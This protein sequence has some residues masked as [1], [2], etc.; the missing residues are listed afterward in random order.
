MPNRRD[1]LKTVAGAAAGLAVGADTFAQGAA[2]ARRRAM[3]AGRRVT[4]VDVHAHTFVPEVWDLVKDTPL[5]ASARN[6]LTG[7][8]ALG[9]G[10]AARLQYMDKE[11]ID[12]QAINV[13]A[14]GYSADRALARDLV[15]LQNEKI[16]AA[17]A[18]YPDRFVGMAT[19]ALQHPDLAADQLD[20]A[21]NK[22]GLRGGA[23]GGSVEGQELSDRKFDP[24]WAKAEQLG[25]L[26]FM[27]PQQA[28]GTT[29]NPRLNGKGALGNRIGNPLETTVFLSHLIF[30]GVFDRFPGLRICGA[31]AGGYLASYSGRSDAGCDRAAGD[32][33]RAL[34]K[35]PSEYFKKEIVIDTMIFHEEGLRHLV[36]EVGVGQM[37][38]G[39]DYPFDWPVGIDFIL[40]APFLSNADKEAMLGGNAMKMLRITS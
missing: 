38:Y 2:G 14:W 17:V 33:C 5:A 16:A 1:F 11:G 21:V 27:H 10:T 7:A 28:P 35:K 37:V 29:A 19:L 39:T 12:Y 15:Q 6:N 26:L 32:D 36:A 25:V 18:Q 23:I 13:N 31:H 20:Y 24:F 3:I 4:V 34:K 9:P 8:I 22:L 30:E 40:K